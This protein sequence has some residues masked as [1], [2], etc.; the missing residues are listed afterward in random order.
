MSSSAPASPT[1]V[2][3]APYSVFLSTIASIQQ[4]HP[5]NLSC[6]H[7][8][9]AY[10]RS[11]P[12]SDQAQLHRILRSG[13]QNPASSMGCYALSAADYRRF[14]PFFDRVIRA[15]HAIIGPLHH[16]SDWRLPP[17]PPLDLARLALPP[18]SVRVRVGRNL[19]AFPL[20]A[21]MALSD[22]TALETHMLAVFDRLIARPAYG[23]RYHS[24]TPA[25]PHAVSDQQYA[26]LVRDHLMFKDMSADPYLASAGI[27]AH[28][29]HG[30]GCYVSENKDV[31]VWVGEEDHLRIMCMRTTTVLND[32]LAT[33]EE[34]CNAVEEGAG[35]FAVSDDYGYVTSCPTNLG[36]GMRASLHLKLPNLTSGGS[37]ARVKEVCKPLGL[38][39]RG[40]GGEHTSVGQDGTV[41]IS[42]SARL[43]IKEADILRALYNGAEKLL[44]EERACE[45]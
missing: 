9:A 12:P 4:T 3:A 20:P 45:S 11:L 34:L 31:L 39:V 1:A 16:R 17:A 13:V 24:L 19:A 22:R 29:P 26:A 35:P 5:S 18:T 8:S 30:R 44:E 32:V 38:S 40:V 21:A 28:W 7:F 42:P 37:D 2:A 10:F 23:G 27:S 6:A 43:C 36:T 33:L 25:T 15:H 14:R 41:D